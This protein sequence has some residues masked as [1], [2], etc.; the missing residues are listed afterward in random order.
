MRC[1][2]TC[3]GVPERLGPRDQ[4]S[5]LP[6]GAH[7]GLTAVDPSDLAGCATRRAPQSGAALPPIF[8][9]DC[10]IV[11]APAPQVFRK[12]TKFTGASASSGAVDRRRAL[13]VSPLALWLRC[14]VTLS[15]PSA[16]PTRR[17]GSSKSFQLQRA[18]AQRSLFKNKKN[19]SQK[20]VAANRHG[21]IAKTKKG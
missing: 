16:Q 18:M 6:C 1:A 17:E 7:P 5:S 8:R 4:S 19:P 13:A 3:G 14:S 2:W 11:V 21:K 12:T 10:Q 9:S 15:I 20:A